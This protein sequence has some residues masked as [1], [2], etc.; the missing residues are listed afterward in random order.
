MTRPVGIPSHWILFGKYSDLVKANFGPAFGSA[1]ITEDG[2]AFTC[3]GPNGVE[4]RFFEAGQ[5]GEVWGPAYVKEF[6]P[7]SGVSSG[8]ITVMPVRPQQAKGESIYDYDARLALYREDMKK[9]EPNLITKL[10]KAAKANSV[11]FVMCEFK[12]DY[13]ELVLSVPIE[14]GATEV[15]ELEKTA[16]QSVAEELKI[17]T[18]V[19]PYK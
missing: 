4:Y 7:P 3:V 14:A 2:V 19:F 15:A 10:E 17:R 8:I 6:L 1:P 9:S 5:T 18:V 11:R 13:R 12:D 16:T